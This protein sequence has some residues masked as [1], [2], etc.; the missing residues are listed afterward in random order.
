MRGYLLHPVES[1]GSR[2]GFHRN[3]GVSMSLGG[4]DVVLYKSFIKFYQVLAS[5]IKPDKTWQCKVLSSFIK[6]SPV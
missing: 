3:P 1:G 4:H 2:T 5:F 6:L